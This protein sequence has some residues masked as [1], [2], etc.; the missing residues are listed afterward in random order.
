MH[1]STEQ[2]LPLTGGEIKAWADKRHLYLGKQI[3]VYVLIYKFLRFYGSCFSSS[4]SLDPKLMENQNGKGPWE[5]YHSTT[6]GL[7][8]KKLRKI[9]NISETKAAMRHFESQFMKNCAGCSHLGQS[10]VVLGRTTLLPSIWVLILLQHEYVTA[11]SG[12]KGVCFS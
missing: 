5:N 6:S 12:M 4:V 3:N 8:W 11:G 9:F 10:R 7:H 2:L 1:A